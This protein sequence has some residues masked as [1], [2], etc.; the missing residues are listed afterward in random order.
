MSTMTEGHIELRKQ[1]ISILYRLR[2]CCCLTL[3]SLKQH[4]YRTSHRYLNPNARL[5]SRRIFTLP[6]FCIVYPG[7]DYNGHLSS[8]VG[9]EKALNNRLGY[10]RTQAEFETIMAN[11]SLAPPKQLAVAVP[12]NMLDGNAVQE[13]G[14]PA[15]DA[16]IPPPCQSCRQDGNGPNSKAS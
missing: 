14:R 7:H 5:P 10:G 11:L 6:D 12:A 13:S 1:T 9:E 15:A 16:V 2:A 8:T 4:L 3:S